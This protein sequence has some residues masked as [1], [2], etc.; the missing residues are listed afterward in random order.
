MTPGPS[1]CELSDQQFSE[2]LHEANSC[3]GTDLSSHADTFVAT[4]C[5]AYLMAWMREARLMVYEAGP[6]PDGGE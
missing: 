4:L 1:L 2:V 3:G 6:A 5:A